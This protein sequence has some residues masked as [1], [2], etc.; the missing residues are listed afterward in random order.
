M[1][2]FHFEKVH[3]AVTKA[4][5]FASSVFMASDVLS[6]DATIEEVIV[7]AQKKSENLPKF[8]SDILRRNG[9]RNRYVRDWA[10]WM[11]STG[12]LE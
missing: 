6:Q 7:T 3:K 5:V 9:R 8:K 2:I 1:N 12:S 10:H 11:L 4:T